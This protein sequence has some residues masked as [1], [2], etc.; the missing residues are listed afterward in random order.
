MQNL[1]VTK[2]AD[3]KVMINA[4]L[5]RLA[6]LNWKLN[7]FNI[8]I[9]QLLVFRISLLPAVLDSSYYLVDKFGKGARKHSLTQWQYVHLIQDGSTGRKHCK[10]N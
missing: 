5:S 2:M 10:S 4:V 1:Y 7:H 9:A 8:N 6:L 3:I